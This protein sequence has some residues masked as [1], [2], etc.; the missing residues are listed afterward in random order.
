MRGDDSFL[1]FLSFK[2]SDDEG[3]RQ[4]AVVVLKVFKSFKSFTPPKRQTNQILMDSKV[5]VYRRK[6][7]R[8]QEKQ[9]FS[10]GIEK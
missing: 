7:P 2:K 10:A 5:P 1:V 4:P 8:L 3:R 9:G 6:G